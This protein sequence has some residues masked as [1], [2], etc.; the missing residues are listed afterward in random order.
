MSP[1]LRSA[2][3]EADI[4]AETAAVRSVLMIWVFQWVVATQANLLCQP[5]PTSSTCSDQVLHWEFHLVSCWS[6]RSLPVSDSRFL[7]CF[8]Q[9][10][11]CES[12]LGRYL[13]RT[14]VISSG[15]LRSDAI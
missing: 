8:S 4:S 9:R 2:N 14:F 1:V 5:I 12:M 13:F 3:A 7:F 15:H 11:E 10:V 6:S